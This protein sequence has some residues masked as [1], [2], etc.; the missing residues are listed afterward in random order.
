MF[1]ENGIY[2][3]RGIISLSPTRQDRRF[4]NT[5][6]YVIFTDVAKYLPW[7][8]EKVPELKDISC[9]IFHSE[10]TPKYKYSIALC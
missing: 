10:Y 6:E 2:R 8:Y 3:I 5:T 4:C 7:I 9:T 1:E